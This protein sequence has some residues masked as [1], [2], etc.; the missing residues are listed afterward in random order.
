M[1][2]DIGSEEHK[3]C[4]GFTRPS[5]TNKML[6]KCPVLLAVVMIW[7]QATS[8][9]DGAETVCPADGHFGPFRWLGDTDDRGKW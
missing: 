4:K 9:H 3:Y 2:Y 7:K 5:P 8:L 1:R 6:Y